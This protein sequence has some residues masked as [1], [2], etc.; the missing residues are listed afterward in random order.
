MRIVCYFRVFENL[1]RLYRDPRLPAFQK[2]FFRVSQEPPYLPYMGDLISRLLNRVPIL[3][4]SFYLN[5]NSASLNLS[6]IPSETTSSGTKSSTQAGTTSTLRKILSTLRVLPPLEENGNLRKTSELYRRKL[7]NDYGNNKIVWLNI[8]S[9]F[10]ENCQRAAS[11]Y[12]LRKNDL[13]R[14]YL[15]K[16]RYR[17]DREN[18]INS[19]SVE[20]QCY[21]DSDYVCNF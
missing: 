7:D 21:I 3:K 8:A 5:P 12:V 17:E 9:E 1:C 19:F 2:A 20:K 13:A 4:N 14:E 18:F 11:A 10:L 16:A 6:S 15:L